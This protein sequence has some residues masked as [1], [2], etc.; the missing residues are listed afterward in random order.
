LNENYIIKKGNSQLL[1]RGNA[2]HESITAT[3]GALKT[4][5]HETHSTQENFTASNRT[6]YSYI[7]VVYNSKTLYSRSAQLRKFEGTK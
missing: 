4:L 7:L 1:L 3:N 5:Q 2:A 6:T